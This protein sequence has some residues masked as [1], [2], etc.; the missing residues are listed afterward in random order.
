MSGKSCRYMRYVQ[1]WGLLISYGLA[2]LEKTTAGIRFM[3]VLIKIV[4]V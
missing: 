1:L 2:I 4:E 3:K